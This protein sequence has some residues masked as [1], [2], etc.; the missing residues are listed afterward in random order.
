[1]KI[2]YSSR[3]ILGRP[4]APAKSAVQNIMIAYR[5]ARELVEYVDICAEWI[6]KALQDLFALCRYSRT[7]G[8]FPSITGIRPNAID[9]EIYVVSKRQNAKVAS[10]ANYEFHEFFRIQCLRGPL[11]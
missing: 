7:L 3:N 5:Y 9:Y 6:D 10:K 8:V 2:N 1:M 4:N 11:A